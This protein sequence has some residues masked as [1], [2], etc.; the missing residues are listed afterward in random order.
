LYLLKTGDSSF[1]KDN[2]NQIKSNTHQIEADLSGPDGILNKTNDIDAN[3]YWTVDDAS[4]LFGLTTYHYL[5]ARLDYPDEAN[6]AESLY[7]NLL[8]AVN[9]KLI[10]TMR[11]NAIDYLTC[12]LTQP[13]SVNRCNNP[14]DANWASMLLFGRWSWD[15][16]LFGANQNGPLL[17]SIDATYTYG[18]NRLKGLLPE[19][20]YGAYPG[21]STTYNAGYGRSGLRGTQYR[22]EAILDYQ[23]MLDNTQSSPF[24]WWES[25]L[26]PQEMGWEGVHPAGGQGACPH[27][28]GQS[29]ATSALLDSLVVE[30]YDGTLVVGRGI[31]DS[32]VSKGKIIEVTNYPIS[33]N[34]RMGLRIEGLADN[35]VS[36]TLTGET[37]LGKVVF[38]LPVFT[39]NIQSSSTGIADSLSGEVRLDAGTSEVIVK[40]INF[41]RVVSA[42]K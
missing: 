15:G 30:K 20:T 29:F 38:N 21:Y 11:N 12:E 24:G 22:D 35:Q 18:F 26:P 7:M 33:N 28:W 32:W 25:I 19:H 9:Q 5:A 37:P 4:A 23:F 13:N 1:V 17:N 14:T 39:D 10:Q 27:M 36:L 41:P 40:L 6:W 2:F 31:P 34:T 8:T 42:D 16:Y 3:G